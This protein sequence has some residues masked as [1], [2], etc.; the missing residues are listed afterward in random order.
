MRVFVDEAGLLY[1]A[2]KPK[3]AAHSEKLFVSEELKFILDASPVHLSEEQVTIIRDHLRN[4]PEER[5]KLEQLAQEKANHEV[6]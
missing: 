3:Q 6:A 4:Y 5:V 1:A 2:E